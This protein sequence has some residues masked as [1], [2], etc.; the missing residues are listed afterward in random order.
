MEQAGPEERK[1]V[2]MV[3]GLT[4]PGGYVC[5]SHLASGLTCPGV[6]RSAL[7]LLVA[8]S[9]YGRG[10]WRVFTHIF[11]CSRALTKVV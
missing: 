1:L 8:H 7:F 9:Y 6:H 4:W 10:L 3:S 5:S 11:K 2:A